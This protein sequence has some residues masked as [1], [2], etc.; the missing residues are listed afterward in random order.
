M[1]KCPFVVLTYCHYVLNLLLSLLF[2]LDQ[3]GQL[4]DSTEISRTSC[5]LVPPRERK[6]WTVKNEGEY[7]APLVEVV[8]AGVDGVPSDPVRSSCF[9]HLF[10]THFVTTHALWLF[11]T[12]F[13]YVVIVSPL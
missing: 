9:H 1:R 12:S 11:C 13:S 2:I 5:T 8:E 4:Y 7:P 3:D 10:A 6:H